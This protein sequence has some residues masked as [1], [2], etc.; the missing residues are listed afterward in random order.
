M[1]SKTSKSQGVSGLPR[2]PARPVDAHKGIFGRVLVVGGSLAMPGSVAL[3]A[4]AA[5][6]SGAG[7]VRIFCPA[8]AQ[9][10]AMG[11]A[12]CCTSAPADQTPNGHF[13]LKARRQL[14]EQAAEHDVL[15][16]GPGMGQSP[17][18]ARLVETALVQTGK[19]V[20]L[21]ADGLNN[22]AWLGGVARLAGPLV[23]TPHPGEAGRLLRAFSLNVKLSGEPRSRQAAARALADHLGCIVVLK[24]NG[25]VVTDGKRLYVN[26]TGN[27][28]MASGGTGDVLTGVIAALVGQKLSPYDAAVLGTYLHGLAGDIAADRLGQHSLMAGDMLGT[29]PEAFMRHA[30][31]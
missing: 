29:L 28:G 5:Y 12:M 30:S 25:T 7:L 22:L 26:E 14:L 2:L 31:H 4:N 27:P 3:V 15:A 13:A 19:P 20:V 9:P 16:M 11:L 17:A 1:P 6:R 21:D 24:G 10:I 18:C 23:I 8:S